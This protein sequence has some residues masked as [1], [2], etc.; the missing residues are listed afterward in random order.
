VA[1]HSEQPKIQWRLEKTS[2]GSSF[3]VVQRKLKIHLEGKE[4]R[5]EVQ[6]ETSRF[7]QQLT[8]SLSSWL[9]FGR[10]NFYRHKSEELLVPW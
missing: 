8:L 10:I 9:F 1:V 4:K 6:K 3:E 5:P 2:P 7:V